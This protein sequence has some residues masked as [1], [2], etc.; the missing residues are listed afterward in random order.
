MHFC[1]NAA[2]LD[3]PSK[4]P[5]ESYG[6]DEESWQFYREQHRELLERVLS[7]GER[8]RAMT[9]EQVEKLLEY[10]EQFTFTSLKTGVS[11]KLKQYP[12]YYMGCLLWGTIDGNLG[13][14]RLFRVLASKDGF[15]EAWKEAKQ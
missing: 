6:V 14:E 7:D 8:A 15:M 12:T 2:T 1:N 11:R 3:K 5:G 4:Y 13:T 9:M 10:Y